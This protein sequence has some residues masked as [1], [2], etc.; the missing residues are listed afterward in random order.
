MIEI[1]KDTLISEVIDYDPDTALFFL[2]MGMHCF[3]CF[4]AQ[5]E[6]IEEA[7]VVHGMDCQALIDILNDYFLHKEAEKEDDSQNKEDS[8][9]KTDSEG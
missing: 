9:Q 7:C 4:M 5:G 1:T 2:E 6:T 8:N 3:S